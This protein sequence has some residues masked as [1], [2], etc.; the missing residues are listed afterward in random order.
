M[1]WKASTLVAIRKARKHGMMIDDIADLT[2]L[3]G[4][5]VQLGLD[6]LNGR[7]PD[8]AAAWLNGLP[9]GDA[10]VEVAGG[11]A[12]AVEVVTKAVGV[13]AP[14]VVRPRVAVP[15]PGWTAPVTAESPLPR[16]GLELKR[17]D[18]LVR[19]SLA[20]GGFAG[21]LSDA[22]APTRKLGPPPFSQA[23]GRSASR[24]VCTP[25]RE[26]RPIAP[27]PPVLRPVKPLT[28]RVVGWARAFL[29]AGW[30]VDETAGLF[31]VD[32]EVLGEEVAA[33]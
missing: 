33:C 20:A 11:E 19:L 32:P 27:R 4:D 12:V 14:V 26:R 8:Q 24:S 15:P 16:D 17:D 21:M 22:S 31:D 13:P 10:V 25:S 6:S 28:R 7:N 30:G 2:D 3:T 29:A 1:I 18:E 5:E 23:I 9:P